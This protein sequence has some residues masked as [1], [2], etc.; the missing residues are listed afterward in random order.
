MNIIL[1][2][3]MSPVTDAEHAVTDAEHAALD[4]EWHQA[5]AALRAA[6]LE[7]DADDP[8]AARYRSASKAVNHANRSRDFAIASK[9]R[10]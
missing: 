5:F 9:A 10:R 8:I 4:A 3:S 2:G 6:G 7:S 1:R